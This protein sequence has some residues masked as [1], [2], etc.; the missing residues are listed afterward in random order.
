MKKLGKIIVIILVILLIYNLFVFIDFG[1]AG[2]DKVRGKAASIGAKCVGGL[3]DAFD[4]LRGKLESKTVV[5]E[6]NEQ[7]GEAVEYVYPAPEATPAAQ[8]V[9]EITVAPRSSK[10][11]A[12]FKA[13]MDNY[14]AF[15]DSYIEFMQSCSEN[16]ADA[17][18][19]AELPTWLDNYSKNLDEMSAIDI[20]KLSYGDMTYYKIVSVRINSKLFN[21]CAYQDDDAE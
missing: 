17:A 5:N 2:V 19:Q 11:S 9:P 15:F 14:E 1:G 13:K 12:A 3:A 7:N 10:P 16:P 8:P 18:L 21:A 4:S 6:K 20:N